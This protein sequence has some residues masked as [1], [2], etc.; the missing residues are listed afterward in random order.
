MT[1]VLLVA[2][3]F[4]GVTLYLFVN[5][6]GKSKADH[7]PVT[8]SEKVEAFSVEYG[9]RSF[10]RRVNEGTW[11]SID[12]SPDGERLA[13]D[14]LGDIYQ[15]DI[16]GG[17]AA[18]L[19]TGPYYEAMPRYSPDGSSITFVSDRSG[20][21][22]VHIINLKGG[23]VRQISSKP[24]QQMF[25]PEWSHDGQYIFATQFKAI[26]TGARP[27]SVIRYDTTKE[28]LP[29]TTLSSERV[30]GQYSGVAVR[31]QDTFLTSIM[32]GSVNPFEVTNPSVIY[33]FN[34]AI[35][36]LLPVDT[37][38]E[39]SLKPTLSPS[40]KL[41]AFIAADDRQSC[42][43]LRDL[44]T[45]KQRELT[46]EFRRVN[47][48]NRLTSN[49]LV[50]H[51]SFTPDSE[52]IIYSHEGKIR[53]LSVTSGHHT[54]IPFV[55]NINL[56]M[57]PLGLF[58][59]D[60][61]IEEAEVRAIRNPALSP[62]G[63][64]VAFEAFG[65][66]WLKKID[67]ADNRT[68]TRAVRLTQLGKIAAEPTW[69]DDSRYLV[70]VTWDNEMGGAIRV[71]ELGTGTD[72]A[73][74]SD[75]AFYTG[76]VVSASGD[77]VVAL[78]GN[79]DL[80]R[81]YQRD[82]GKRDIV[83]FHRVSGEEV[84]LDE[85]TLDHISVNR[86]RRTD[87]NCQVSIFIPNMRNAR[88]GIKVG[89]IRSYTLPDNGCSPDKTQ[90][91]SVD[92]S[93]GAPSGTIGPREL[94]ASTLYKG[95][96]VQTRSELI[97]IDEPFLEKDEGQQSRIKL[98][99]MDASA[100]RYGFMIEPDNFD[101][102]PA[103]NRMIITEGT[104]IR[105]HSLS[106][107]AHI[108]TRSVDLKVAKTGALGSLLLTNARI[109][110]MEGDRVLEAGDVLIENGII[111]H[112]G[113]VGSINTEKVTDAQI[114]DLSGKTLLPGYVDLHAHTRPGIHNRRIP[115]SEFAGFEIY[116]A[117]GVTS[118]REAG[119]ASVYFSDL[120][121]AGILTGPRLLAAPPINMRHSRSDTA[122]V[123]TIE[124]IASCCVDQTIKNWNFG[125]R[126]LEAL[127]AHEQY[128]RGLTATNHLRD[129]T[130]TVGLIT[131]GFAGIEHPVAKLPYEDDFLHFLSKS[132]VTYTPTL[133]DGKFGTDLLFFD[134]VARNSEK[135][136]PF[137][138]KSRWAFFTRPPIGKTPSDYY[139]YI[140]QNLKKV[141]DAGGRIGLG[142]HGDLWGLDCHIEL[143]AIASGGFEPL[144]IL[145]IGTQNG[146]YAIGRGSQIGSV[147]EGKIA[148]LQILD[149]NPLEDIRNTTSVSMVMKEG[150]LYDAS[151]L[152]QI[153]PM[154]P[155]ITPN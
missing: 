31:G 30:M 6:F 128:E 84:T 125:N 61:N 146:A 92:L 15:L 111:Q 99:I 27:G 76:P 91:I 50:P 42:I 54:I 1:R 140:A 133:S 38:F 69:S 28:K 87:S 100:R 52:H 63:K 57:R 113:A 56:P 105:I 86:L 19:L 154:S 11:M 98:N 16:E 138:P 37:G 24:N 18:P 85:V 110:T 135:L 9:E 68:D 5:P 112:V 107:G 118:L 123:N 104:E 117:L 77:W 36:E 2:L 73:I 136:E 115:L 139:V 145:R 51:F 101:F 13:F 26:G 89:E 55:V 151:N 129:A 96:F 10:Q 126:R 119:T 40:R 22:Q 35:E 103:S 33:I 78:R 132:G 64:K 95:M 44:K 81:S 43:I 148:D 142:C 120:L 67:R 75:Q 137:L 150:V 53:K 102:A 12:V 109:I 74:S 21:R 29:E 3:A 155:S 34:H 58:D 94:Y 141:H 41:L 114:F 4:A 32:R 82:T 59:Y 70:Y 66:L 25:S 80:R 48:H 106:D 143:W 60:I 90:S 127:A 88:S 121:E 149:E 83:A 17:V 14:L 47:L 45:K 72:T 97:H 152:E 144:E 124:G 93:E 122:L 147:T 108:E 79:A 62:D 134:A 153:W 46:C 71:R 49:D 131:D 20:E 65:A 7:H 130:H 8:I 23:E 39:N 116:L